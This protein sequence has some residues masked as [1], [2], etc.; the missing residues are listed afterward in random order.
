MKRFLASSLLLVALLFC[1]P[2]AG[3]VSAVQAAEDTVEMDY[4]DWRYWFDDDGH[5]WRRIYNYT[6]QE[7]E[8]EPELVL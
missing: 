8:G 4:K 6:T 3:N 7:W 2:V 5:L 1:L